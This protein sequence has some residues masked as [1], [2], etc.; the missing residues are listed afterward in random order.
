MPV[1][2][3]SNLRRGDRDHLDLVAGALGDGI[4]TADFLDHVAKEIETV[5]LGGG[6]GV[7]IDDAAPDGVV[8]GRF[9]DGFGIVVEGV[10]FLEEPGEGMGL[11]G[12]E[13]HFPGREGLK[14]GNGLE[15]RGGRGHG[16]QGRGA[17]GPGGAEPAQH[18][19]AVGGGGEG[20][21]H[22]ATVGHGLGQDEDLGS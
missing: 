18:G 16:Y 13:G 12:G 22:V 2:A 20:L 10:E 1:R 19:D 5:G 11:A 9:A 17:R 8:S 4:E 3:A 6:D 14:G 15:Q 21:P 7:H